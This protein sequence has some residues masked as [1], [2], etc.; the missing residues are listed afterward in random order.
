MP[1]ST[2]APKAQDASATEPAQSQTQRTPTRQIA[3]KPQIISRQVFNDF[4]SI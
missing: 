4:A 2:P 1:S 3:A